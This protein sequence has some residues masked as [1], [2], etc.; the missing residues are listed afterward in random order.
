MAKRLVFSQPVG[1][2]RESSALRSLRSLRA[3]LTVGIMFWLDHPSYKFASD[4]LVKYLQA[5]KYRFRRLPPIIFLCGAMNSPARDTLNHY[6]NKYRPD[7]PLF[8]AERVWNEIATSTELNALEMEAYLAALADVLI[9][10]VESPGTFAELGAFSL[11]DALRKKLLPVLDVRFRN[12]HSFLETGPVRWINADSDYRPPVYVDLRKILEAI[13][14]IE[15]RLDRIPSA[16]PTKVEDLAQSPKHLLFFMCDLLAIIEPATSDMI[17]HYIERIVPTVT[18]RQITTLVGLGS[19]MR[20]LTPAQLTLDGVTGTFYYR[21]EEDA[22]TRP[23]HH[24]MLQ[25]LPTQRAAQMSVLLTIPQATQAL[26]ELG[27][28]L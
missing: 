23:F 7:L 5:E 15:E 18:K 22:L 16:K 21:P 9:I 2:D 12:Q 4:R 8:Y 19:A 27:N 11:S 25:D 10:L 14:Q 3:E 1:I 13:D 24:K 26:R 6:L 17:G 28:L 20:L